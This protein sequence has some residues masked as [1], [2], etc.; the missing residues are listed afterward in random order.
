MTYH[1]EFL[2]WPV[3]QGISKGRSVV[4]HCQALTQLPYSK[5]INHLQVLANDLEF[6]AQS[7]HSICQ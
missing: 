3:F 5:T 4:G 2:E 6:D 1:L 7:V